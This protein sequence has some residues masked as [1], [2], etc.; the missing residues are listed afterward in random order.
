M[1]ENEVKKEKASIN[2]NIWFIIFIVY[3][4]LSLVYIF[5][6]NKTIEN[7]NNTIASLEETTEKANANSLN[8]LKDF[9]EVFDKYDSILAEK[10][11]VPSTT[12]NGTYTGSATIS[13]DMGTTL[14]M[15]LTLSENNIASLS[16]VDSS[17]DSVYNGVYSITED[18]VNFTSDDGLTNYSFV[19][20]DENTLKLVNDTV[21]L[22]LTK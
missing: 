20:L 14:S 16:V 21:E 18:T 8:I 12:P 3:L 5:S 9:K 13:G 17:G 6:L 11:E 4:V 15:T 10:V 1:A 2:M 22:S 19:K 7:Q